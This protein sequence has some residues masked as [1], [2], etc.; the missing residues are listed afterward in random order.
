M[1][2]QVECSN[3]DLHSGVYGGSVHEAMTDL[4]MLM[5]ERGLRHRVAVGREVGAGTASRLLHAFCPSLPPPA[6]DWSL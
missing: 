4:I 6:T 3:R 5:G 1:C 2:P